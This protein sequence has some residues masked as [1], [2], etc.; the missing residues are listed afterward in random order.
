MIV[1]A[2]DGET[3]DSLCWRALGLTG[4]VTEKAYDLNPG[5]ADIGPRLPGGTPVTLPDPS[6]SPVRRR[7]TVKLWD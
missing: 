1:T 6:P 5:L 7:A 4:S 2:R 3:V